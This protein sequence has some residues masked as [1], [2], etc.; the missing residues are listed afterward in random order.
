MEPI[1]NLQREICT[2]CK[3]TKPQS[4]GYIITSSEAVNAVITRL[5]P[6]IVSV[7]L[8]SGFIFKKI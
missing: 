4:P 6:V 8:Q 5:A 2:Y 3:L 7:A 1:P